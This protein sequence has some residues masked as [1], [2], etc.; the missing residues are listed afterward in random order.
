MSWSSPQQMGVDPPQSPLSRHP[1]ATSVAALQLEGSGVH[2]YVVVA[3]LTPSFD[4]AP[5]Q[6]GSDDVHV[7]ELPQSAGTTAPPPPPPP[8]PEA[9]LPPPPPPPLPE[10]DFPESRVDFASLPASVTVPPSE[11]EP[12]NKSESTPL[13]AN[14]P[15]ISEENMQ[16]TTASLRVNPAI[17]KGFRRR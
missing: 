14:A 13:H 7:S 9:T 2:V 15:T 11:S 17:F 1:T 16:N 12:E 10:S 6:V 3:V 4:C 5:Q 8:P